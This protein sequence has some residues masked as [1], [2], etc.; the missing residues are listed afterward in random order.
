MAMRLRTLLGDH[1]C[2]AALKNGSIRSDLVEFDFVAGEMHDSRRYRHPI[3]HADRRQEARQKTRASS[4][5]VQGEFRAVAMLPVAEFADVARVMKQRGN[6][7]HDRPLGTETHSALDRALIPDEKPRHR[8]GHIQ[9]ML[10]IVIDRI[11]AVVAGHAAGKQ[12][13]E[14]FKGNS[15]SVERLARK[16]GRE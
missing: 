13:V 3:F 10:A 12:L 15:D 16:S 7:R 9:R 11:H 14:F 6:Q 8:Q 2:T 1:T 5:V 4:H